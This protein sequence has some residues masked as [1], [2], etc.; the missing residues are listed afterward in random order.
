MGMLQQAT[1]IKTSSSFL[2]LYVELL[3]RL[4]CA[5]FINDSSSFLAAYQ[6]PLSFMYDGLLK[7][8]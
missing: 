3:R 1:V 5:T 7:E 4:I 8:I 6:H 2:Q